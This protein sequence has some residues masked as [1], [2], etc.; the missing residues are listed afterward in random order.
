MPGDTPNSANNDATVSRVG[1]KLPPFWKA[2]PAL[3][4]VQLEAQFALAGIT[5]DDTK[6]NHVVSA[7]DSDILNCVSDIILKPPDTDKYPTLKKRLIE[8]HSESEASKIRTLLQGLELGDQ[9]PSQLLARM[10]TLAG[11]AVGEPLLKSLW[12]GR[13]PNST[14]TILTALNEDLAGLASVADKINDLAGYSNINS[15]T[16]QSSNNQIAQLE[17]QVA[18]LTTLVGELTTT[19]RQS[20]SQS[21]NRNRP[22]K[23]SRSC[24]RDRLKKYKEPAD[25]ICFYHTN[26][27]TKAKK[28]SLPCSFKNSGN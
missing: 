11:D 14:Q 28:C 10:K 4:F 18:H 16:P 17:K 25:G 6:F 19:M 1:V 23:N 13:L 15:V 12:L 5:A 22:F 20:R 8:L 26:F 7:V 24:S 3:W 27:G 21:R 2:N 9:R